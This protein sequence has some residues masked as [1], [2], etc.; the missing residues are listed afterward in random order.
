MKKTL[1]VLLLLLISFGL[2]GCE[3]EEV[4]DDT[5]VIDVPDEV[6]INIQNLP[7]IEHLLQSNECPQFPVY[8]N[9]PWQDTTVLI[10][11][12][13]KKESRLYIFTKPPLIFC[14]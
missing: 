4:I 5:F 2:Y 12:F 3:K 14:K 10:L 7:Y 1:L 6:F 13:A 8:I 11:F 9:S